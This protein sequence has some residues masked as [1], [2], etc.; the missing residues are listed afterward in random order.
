MLPGHGKD[1]IDGSRQTG[2]VIDGAGPVLAGASAAVEAV[3]TVPESVLPA[4]AIVR[5]GIRMVEGAMVRRLNADS[6]A[7]DSKGRRCEGRFLH[8][9]DVG[10]GQGYGR[11][12]E[13]PLRD[14]LVES[15]VRAVGQRVRSGTGPAVAGGA[16]DLMLTWPRTVSPAPGPIGWIVY[17]PCSPHLQIIHR[18]T[19]GIVRPLY[20][21][22]GLCERAQSLPRRVREWCASTWMP[23]TGP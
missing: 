22:V 11:R 4:A 13:S 16:G 1:G 2:Q 3:G 19:Q 5:G 10:C 20:R 7:E 8:G 9:V 15:P 18:M 21:D 6:V 23:Q 17:V 14:R 12:W